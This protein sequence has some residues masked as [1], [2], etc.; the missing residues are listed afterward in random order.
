MINSNKPA[1]ELTM[2]FDQIESA[3]A[4]YSIAKKAL[5]DYSMQVLK[6]YKA[7]IPSE[8]IFIV[9][10]FGTVLY[11]GDNERE[12]LKMYHNSES[13]EKSFVTLIKGMQHV[14][15]QRR[16]SAEF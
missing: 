11:M 5:I 3:I 1:T 6:Q 12:A 14:N 7:P 10:S 4:E 9:S 16:Y 2:D 15:H 8:D 13:N